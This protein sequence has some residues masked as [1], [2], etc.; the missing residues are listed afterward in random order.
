MSELRFKKEFTPPLFE[1]FCV[2]NTKKEESAKELL[3]IEALV[4]SIEKE[5]ER[6]FG[7]RTL[8]KLDDILDGKNVIY[9]GLP[10]WYGLPEELLKKAT[11]PIAHPTIKRA[12]EKLISWYEPR[13]KN[14][15]VSVLGF[16]ALSQSLKIEISAQVFLANKWEKINFT[17]QT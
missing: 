10:G 3:P 7:S 1:K 17:L 8:K 9:K 13:L 12:L 15:K 4:N 6:L 5:L 14:A 2:E 16:D 11:A